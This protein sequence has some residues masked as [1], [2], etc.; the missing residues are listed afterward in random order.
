MLIAY[1]YA[2]AASDAGTTTASSSTTPIGVIDCNHPYFLHNSDNPGTPF[3]SQLLTESNYPQWSRS[4]SIALS[5]RLK[6][7]LIDENRSQ[8]Y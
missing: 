5:A 3:V 1:S 7:G 6:L 8:T 4:I 2:T